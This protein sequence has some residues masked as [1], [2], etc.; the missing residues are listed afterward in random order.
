MTVYEIESLPKYFDFATCQAARVKSLII[1]VCMK[2]RP[3]YKES[4]PTPKSGLVS[5]LRRGL[6]LLPFVFSA[7]VISFA[8]AILCASDLAPRQVSKQMGDVEV[9]SGMY[10]MTDR[11]GLRWL[12]PIGMTQPPQQELVTKY[13]VADESPSRRGRFAGHVVLDG[14]ISAQETIVSREARDKQS[15]MKVL[16]RAFAETMFLEKKANIH[17]QK[18]SDLLAL[19]DFGPGKFVTF[20]LPY[21]PIPKTEMAFAHV[22]DYASQATNNLVMFKSKGVEYV[23]FFIHP[24]YVGSYSDLIARYGIVYHHHAM[25]TSSPRSLI[26]IDP[27]APSDVHWVKVSLHKKIDGSVR[28]NTDKKARRAIIMSEAIESVPEASMRDYGLRFMLEPAAFQPKGKVASTIHREVAPELLSPEANTKWIPA[29]ILQNTGEDAVPGLNIQDMTHAA[30]MPVEEFVREKI[31]R[32]LLRCY[33]SM[34]L[35]EGL[36]G[37]LHTQNFYYQVRRTQNKTGIGWLPTGEV[38]FKDNDGFRFDTE[39]ALRQ[40]RPM[41]FFARFDEPFFWGKY[42]NTVG[43]GAEGIPFLGSW[44]YKLIRNVNGFETL[45]AYMLRAINKI[46]PQNSQTK[47]SIQR[48]MDDLAAQEVE[49]I[50]GIRLEES[51]YGFGADKGLNKVLNEWRTRLSIEADS[52]QR[53]DQ[54]LQAKLAEQWERLKGL[55]R[56]SGQRRALPADA[57]YLLHRMPDGALLIEARTPRTTMANPDPTVGFAIIESPETPSGR[58]AHLA[59]RSTVRASTKIVLARA[60]TKSVLAQSSTKRCEEVFFQH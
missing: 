31:V 45:A 14:P 56:V 6:L 12:L 51:D 11:F 30:N 1:K 46:D 47:E 27:D 24:N 41:N 10:L 53:N 38:M 19:G 44:Y 23:R 37:E 15:M 48:M 5:L 2:Q 4:S 9:P 32:P 57:Y 55:K 60:S 43:L 18:S 21:I 7:V 17:A 25:T 42:S 3:K 49:R 59:L 39:L 20:I 36:P 13:F 33:L 50:T 58:A 34:G 54:P 8:P 28:I 16:P 26:V 52:S 40:G 35:I 22:S 29:F